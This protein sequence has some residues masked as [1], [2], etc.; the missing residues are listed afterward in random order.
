MPQSGGSGLFLHTYDAS[1]VP[2]PAALRLLLVSAFKTLSTHWP[3]QPNHFLNRDVKA[4]SGHGGQPAFCWSERSTCLQDKFVWKA[5]A[6]LPL[7]YA[8]NWWDLGSFKFIGALV[9]LVP[10]SAIEM[11]GF[12]V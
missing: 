1:P 10:F 2:V 5:D 8:T 12:G 11:S 4:L 7:T 3:K 9:S 6:W